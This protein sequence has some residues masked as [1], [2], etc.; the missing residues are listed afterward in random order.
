LG[1][2]MRCTSFSRDVTPIQLLPQNAI[3]A[4]WEGNM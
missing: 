3:P 2:F 4:S 1:V